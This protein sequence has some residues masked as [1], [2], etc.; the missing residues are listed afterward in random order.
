MGVA[1]CNVSV[2]KLIL[3]DILYILSI[4]LIYL[5]NLNIALPQKNIFTS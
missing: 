1:I 4:C 2:E 5:K 3:K